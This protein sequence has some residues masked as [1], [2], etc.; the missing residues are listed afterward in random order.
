MFKSTKR[1]FANVNKSVISSKESLFESTSAIAW[2]FG[3]SIG[4]LLRNNYYLRKPVRWRCRWWNWTLFGMFWNF[5]VIRWLS[6]EK[7]EGKIWIWEKEDEE[8]EDEE[9]ED[10]EE[11]EQQQQQQQRTFVNWSRPLWTKRDCASLK[12]RRK[13]DI[14]NNNRLLSCGS[15]DTKNWNDN[16]HQF[17]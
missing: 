17:K 2:I 13:L 1:K 7:K 5:A 11:E 16:K 10:E 8:E 4:N 9:E 3:N 6:V 12:C 14:A 15:F